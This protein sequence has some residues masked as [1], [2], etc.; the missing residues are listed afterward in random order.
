MRIQSPLD[1]LSSSQPLLWSPLGS[2]LRHPAWLTSNS[3]FLYFLWMGNST[4]L[5]N[6]AK[7]RNSVSGWQ[8]CILPFIR[9][10]FCVFWAGQWKL[11]YVVPPDCLSAWACLAGN[12]GPLSLRQRRAE[13]RVQGTR[14]PVNVRRHDVDETCFGLLLKYQIQCRRKSQ[15][16]KWQN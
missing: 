15:P 14:P 3:E 12:P 1:C 2:P 13:R 9:C 16:I 8:I 5:F 6:R 11:A 4:F 7:Y 10:A